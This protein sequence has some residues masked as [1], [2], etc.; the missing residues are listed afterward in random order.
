MTQCGGN[1][2][3]PAGTASASQFADYSP[4]AQFVDDAEL[5]ARWVM[6]EGVVKRRGPA[7]CNHE[8]LRD[9]VAGE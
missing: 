4:Y 7:H 9:C 5:S 6:S 2:E 3:S 1:W 8:N